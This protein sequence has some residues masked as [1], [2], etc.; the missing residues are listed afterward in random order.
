MPTLNKEDQ[1]RLDKL[2]ADWG[3]KYDRFSFSS[4]EKLTVDDL[5]LLLTH[6]PPL[7]ALIREIAHSGAA[8][9]ESTP[10]AFS[11][12]STRQDDMNAPD[13]TSHTADA[14]QIE[15]LQTELANLQTECKQL[16]DNLQTCTQASTQLL[17][18]NKT[19]QQRLAQATEDYQTLEKHYAAQEKQSQQRETELAKLHKQYQQLQQKLEQCQHALEQERSRPSTTHPAV[20]LLRQDST[21]AKDLGLP[22]LPADDDLA[23]LQQTV[24]VLAQ[25][26]SLKRL[27]D[28]LKTRTEAHNRP[29]TAQERE[30]LE[31][32]LAWHNHN[33]RSRPYSL[34]APA[35]GSGFDFNHHQRCK[36]TPSG[37]T[38]ASLWVPGI[39]DAGGK[40]FCKCLVNTK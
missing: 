2:Q 39:A 17:Q 19:L 10:I 15:A 23:A 13:D 12:S 35:A 18:D 22:D 37:E 5:R 11:A 33:W 16:A 21:L 20:T 6:F 32:A 34:V 25:S 9:V 14:D 36:P 31:T 1:E 27:W 4:P 3:K 38:I 26:D 29:A 7:Q 28:I 40:A 30:L 24:A 8:L